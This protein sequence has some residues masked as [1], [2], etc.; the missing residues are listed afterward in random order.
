MFKQ[1]GFEIEEIYG[2]FDRRPYEDGTEQIW[3]A[4]K[5]L[6]PGIY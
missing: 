5:A 1:C 4:R 6:Q 2:D 3:I